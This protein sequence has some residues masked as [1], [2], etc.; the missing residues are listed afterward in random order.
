M[1]LPESPERISTEYEIDRSQ[2]ERL[3]IGYNVALNPEHNSEFSSVDKTKVKDFYERLDQ[4]SVPEHLDDGYYLTSE[5]RKEVL[6]EHI[7]NFREPEEIG[8]I[9]NSRVNDLITEAGFEDIETGIDYERN[10]GRFPNGDYF[11]D[12]MLEE[13]SPS[14]I[15]YS[16]I[17]VRGKATIA[18]MNEAISK[19]KETEG[20]GERFYNNQDWT[21][22]IMKDEYGF[23]G[24]KNPISGPEMHSSK[25]HVPAGKVVELLEEKKEKIDP[26]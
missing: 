1:N 17:A 16:I 14:D 15:A 22:H 5:V 20:Y 18:E 7:D 25:E 6:E 26:Q 19:L 24:D 23:I 11:S 13:L 21:G 8:V 10:S 12:N 2:A 4:P 9:T 3:L